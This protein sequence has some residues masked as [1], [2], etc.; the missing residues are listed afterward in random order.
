MTRQA[1]TRACDQDLLF[2]VTF[3]LLALGFGL[4]S[5]HFSEP[6]FKFLSP[7]LEAEMAALSEGSR[8]LPGYLFLRAGET[9]WGP[10][11]GP[12]STRGW[13]SV[14]GIRF[15]G[16][17]VLCC[18]S[19]PASEGAGEHSLLTSPLLLSFSFFPGRGWRDCCKIGAWESLAKLVV[20][21]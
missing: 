20:T 8:K 13:R 14:L 11:L 3:C 16:C 7:Q 19:R 5:F 12:S 6:G 9:L 2:L 17:Q 1:I 4:C 18:S 21:H 15:P 10:G